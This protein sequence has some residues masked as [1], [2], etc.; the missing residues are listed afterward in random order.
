ME[1]ESYV[2]Y[3]GLYTMYFIHVPVINPDLH[4]SYL[5]AEADVAEQHPLQTGVHGAAVVEKSQGGESARQVPLDQR[6]HALHARNQ[7]L[8]MIHV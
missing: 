7:L 5:G 8:K 2:Y 4:V 3:K 6:H 1:I